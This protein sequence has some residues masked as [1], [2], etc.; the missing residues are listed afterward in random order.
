MGICHHPAFDSYGEIMTSDA[1]KTSTMKFLNLSSPV[2]LKV[3]FPAPARQCQVLTQSSSVSTAK[4]RRS[5]HAAAGCVYSLTAALFL[6]R[7]GCLPTSGSLAFFC[8]AG[9]SQT[10]LDSFLAG[11]SKSRFPVMPLVLLAPRFPSASCR[12]SQALT[13]KLLQAPPS[14]EG[15]DT[16]GSWCCTHKP[17]ALIT[18][19]RMCTHHRVL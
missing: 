14:T 17:D 3:A 18:K 1:M 10:L 11:V 15:V 5:G 16:P 13:P 9:G 8:R 2:F 7:G 12:Q 6:Q 4:H 19:S